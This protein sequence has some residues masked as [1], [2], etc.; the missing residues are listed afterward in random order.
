MST[1]LF[2]IALVGFVGRIVISAKNLRHWG[3]VTVITLFAATICALA[4]YA[5]VSSSIAYTWMWGP[6]GTAAVLPWCVLMFAI[7]YGVPTLLRAAER[8]GSLTWEVPA[9]LLAMVS[10]VAAY[11]I[12]TYVGNLSFLWSFVNPPYSF[13]AGMVLYLVFR[14]RFFEDDG[15]DAGE[16]VRRRM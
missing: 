1:A 8:R 14:A 10:A 5:G 11:D 9:L 12:W 3:I 7:A 15:G 13:L 16:P 4:S 2:I 6:L